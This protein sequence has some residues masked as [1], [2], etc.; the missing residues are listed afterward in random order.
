MGDSVSTNLIFSQIG[1]GILLGE[2]KLETV[3]SFDIKFI[4]VFIP[5]YQRPTIA[6]A[7]LTSIQLCHKI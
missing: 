6:R 1:R 5:L 4:Y 2:Y 7:E 3:S